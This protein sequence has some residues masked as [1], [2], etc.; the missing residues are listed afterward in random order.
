M[1]VAD[2]FAL[3][4]KFEPVGDSERFLPRVKP[5][6]TRDSNRCSKLLHGMVRRPNGLFRPHSA[7]PT[8][9]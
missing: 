5:N 8:K 6:W 3:N 2:G 4:E 7:Q 9:V 1:K